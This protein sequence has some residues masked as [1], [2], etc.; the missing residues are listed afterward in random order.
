[1]TSKKDHHHSSS[2]SNKQREIEQQL[3]EQE[4]A[5]R[6]KRDQ[7]IT[8]PKQRTISTLSD[9]N[10]LNLPPTSP[11]PR[12]HS[13]QRQKL[14]PSMSI[15]DSNPFAYYRLA[16][17]GQDNQICFWDLT[18]DV[19]KERPGQSTTAAA[20]GVLSSSSQRTRASSSTVN[21]LTSNSTVPT[22]SSSSSKQTSNGGSVK[23]HHS[24]ASSLV[25]TARSLF[26]SKHSDKAGSKYP[27]E[28]STDGEET[29]T[30]TTAS[31]I[32]N[33]SL[34]SGNYQRFFF[35]LSNYNNKRLFKINE[36][37]KN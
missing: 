16:S 3:D 17:V 31:I 12:H 27:G 10:N 15:S 30:S 23:S 11:S 5:N 19:L 26:S 14:Q 2:S 21:T 32:K 9:Y 28:M 37:F 25:S 33:S 24:A 18:E 36:K 6:Y 22:V 29:T 8:G 35:T 13:S 34:S 1:M 20:S 4:E 7:K